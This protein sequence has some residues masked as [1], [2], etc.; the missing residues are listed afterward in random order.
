[1]KSLKVVRLEVHNFLGV[2]A[3]KITPQG[4]VIRIEGKNAQGKSSVIN[5]I[6]AALGGKTEMP[7]HPIRNGEN[8]ARIVVD[9]G[10]I[11]VTRK[12]TEKGEYLEVENKEGMSYKSPQTILDSMT[13]RVSMDPQE[14]ID[15]KP[16][17]RR[18]F[19]LELIGEKEKIEQLE[20]EKSEAYDNRILVN[21]EIKTLEGKLDG[22]PEDEDIEEKS[23][24]ELM[25]KLN[26]AQ[27]EDNHLAELRRQHESAIL[28]E[29]HALGRIDDVKGE[30]LRLQGVLDE[31]IINAEDCK[32][33]YNHLSS[34]IAKC[35][36]SSRV[37]EIQTEIESVDEYN[38]RVRSIKNA[39]EIRNDLKK[40]KARSDKLTAKIRTA[41]KE[42]I[43]LLKSSALPLDNI[44]FEDENLIIGDIPF[45]D[46]CESDQLK[47]SMKIGLS[48]NPK[49]RVLRIA[50]GGELDSNSMK[51]VEKFAKEN[52]C[53][54]WLQ[55][56]CDKP[57][58]GFFIKDGEI[59]E[60]PELEL[61]GA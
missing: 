51:E 28:A 15:M 41:E 3:V 47:L 27:E 16:R 1:M 53:Q 17:E 38:S 60:E 11:I 22:A 46:L 43:D 33:K 31:E 14:F 24:S 35:P 26:E 6:W 32:N 56:V 7:V 25:E 19:I 18:E 42:K 52:D 8:D 44:S 50:R 59:I 21:R 34:L 49:I 13:S 10:D 40:T 4:N 20:T 5:S 61:K 54:V 36:P 48:Q 9:L 37:P 23:V 30:I 29:K 57:Q 39:R 12:F 45:D 58:G 55:K 2:K